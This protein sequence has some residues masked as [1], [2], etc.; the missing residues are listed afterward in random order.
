MFIGIVV[1]T[2]VAQ[3]LIVTFG[4]PVTQT[5]GL[6]F[7]SWVICVVLGALSI[8]WGMVVRFF[9]QLF[10]KLKMKRQIRKDFMRL[11]RVEVEEMHEKL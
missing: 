9:G 8:P 4:G 7:L 5:V 6:S 3:F 2:A 10:N 1:V 11:E